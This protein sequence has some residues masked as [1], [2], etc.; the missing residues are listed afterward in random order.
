[1]LDANPV[2]PSVGLHAVIPYGDASYKALRPS[3][4]LDPKT[5]LDL[6][7]FFGLNPALSALKPIWDAK[8]LAIIEAAGSP[9][10]TR[11]HFDAQDY[12]GPVRRALSPP[13]KAG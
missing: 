9:D 10:P 11:S 4:A 2:R 13:E 12:M 7:G 1:M 8:Q 6:D 3:L 5:L